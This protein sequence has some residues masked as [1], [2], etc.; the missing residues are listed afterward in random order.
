MSQ[1]L[2]PTSYYILYVTPGQGSSYWYTNTYYPGDESFIS[3]SAFTF[4][5]KLSYPVDDNSFICGIHPYG[6]GL[7]NQKLILRIGNS[8]FFNPPASSTL[9]FVVR[10]RKGFSSNQSW[11]VAVRLYSGYDNAPPTLLSTHTFTESHGTTWTSHTNSGI[12]APANLDSLW[13]EFEYDAAVDNIFGPIA[14]FL[15]SYVGVVI[16]DPDEDQI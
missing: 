6:A 8:Q 10:I 7:T 3:P 13:V 2:Y 14:A 11:S 4:F 12:T 16:P 5:D 15:I 1:F 9:D